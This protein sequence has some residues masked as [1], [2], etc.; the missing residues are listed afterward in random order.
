[1]SLCM[2]NLDKR[3]LRAILLLDYSHR[4]GCTAVRDAGNGDSPVR[5]AYF[6][7][8]S[9]TEQTTLVPLGS[10]PLMSSVAPMRLA[11]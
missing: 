2:A 5:R 1:M 11:R 3:G 7:P 9:G 10:E 8:S 4:R 6:L